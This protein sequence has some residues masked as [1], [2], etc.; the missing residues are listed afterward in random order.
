MGAFLKLR[1]VGT[2]LIGLLGDRQVLGR[3]GIA[4]PQPQ[5]SVVR[6]TDAVHLGEGETYSFMLIFI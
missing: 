1:H 3:A 5:R 4:P 6:D 2:I